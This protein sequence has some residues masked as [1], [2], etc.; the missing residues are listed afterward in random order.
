MAFPASKIVK[1][2]RVLAIDI[3]GRWNLCRAPGHIP[4]VHLGPAISPVRRG[5]VMCFGVQ[6]F[7]D[8]NTET[9][10]TMLVR[11]QLTFSTCKDFRGL[12]RSE[13]CPLCRESPNFI[14]KGKSML[15]RSWFDAVLWFL[16]LHFK[17]YIFEIENT[18]LSPTGSQA[19]KS[20]RSKWK[21]TVRGLAQ[22][23]LAWRDRFFEIHSFQVLSCHQISPSFQKFLCKRSWN[24]FA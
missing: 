21:P 11:F 22:D 7:R 13:M 14:V 3:T 12:W 9:V 6:N 15:P 5:H 24:Q 10:Q 20:T 1:H 17:A 4:T 16:P 2:W 19:E 18:S 8:G 23:Q